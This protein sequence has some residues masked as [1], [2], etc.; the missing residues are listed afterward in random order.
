MKKLLLLF[1]G[2]FLFFTFSFSQD[3]LYTKLIYEWKPAVNSENFPAVLVLGGSEGGLT[4]GQRWAKILPA[5]GFGVMSLSYFGMNGLNKNLEEIPLEYFHK[6]IDTLKSFKGVDPE[7]IIIICA[8]KG[9]EAGLLV[10]S[11]NKSIK[12]VVAVSPS[13]VVWQNI[14]MTDY[15]TPRSSWKRN[16]LPLPFVGYDF[17]NG[18]ASIRNFYAGALEKP[19]DIKAEIPVE[20]I[21]GRVVLFSGGKDNLWPADKMS[22]V[23]KSKISKTGNENQVIHHYFPEA[24]HSFVIGFSNEEEKKTILEKNKD[25]ITQSGGSVKAFEEAMTTSLKILLNELNNFIK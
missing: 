1:Y 6:A 9:T 22:E 19:Y 13:S 8:S 20:N 23:I 24:G 12:L 11:E 14:N 10:A 4:Y 21:T 18:F 25:R 17:S 5:K 3:S 7:K 2:I 15:I 16:N